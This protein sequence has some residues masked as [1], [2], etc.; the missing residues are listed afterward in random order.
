MVAPTL[1]DI[2]GFSLTMTIITLAWETKLFIPR[3]FAEA[4][5]A[6]LRISSLSVTT[7]NFQGWALQADGAIL[8]ASTIRSSFS[9]STGLSS[10][11][12]SL[13]LVIIRSRIFLASIIINNYL[14]GVQNRLRGEGTPDNSSAVLY[15]NVYNH[16]FCN[17]R[18]PFRCAQT[19]YPASHFQE[20]FYI[21]LH[22]PSQP[23]R[24]L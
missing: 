21:V 20:V 24:L 4:A 14:G 7:M 22:D 15:R 8:P 5:S 16:I 3:S 10:Y 11:F 13:C 9:F 23:G 1:D 17:T 12:L 6:T 18:K 2:F 19:L